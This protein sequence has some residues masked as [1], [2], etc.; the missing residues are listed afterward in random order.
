MM[1]IGMQDL[2][3]LHCRYLIQRFVGFGRRTE[4]LLKTAQGEVHPY[5]SC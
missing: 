2:E 1:E 4:R 3:D 5:L